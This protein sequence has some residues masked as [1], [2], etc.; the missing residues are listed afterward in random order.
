MKRMANKRKQ[1]T[2]SYGCFKA[3][4]RLLRLF[5]PRI[6]VEG[7]QKL[8]GE[9]AIIVGNHCQMHGPIICELYFPCRRYTWCA[10]E[11]MHLKEVPAYAF[12]DFWSRKPKYTHWFYKFLSYVVAP[13][14]VFIFRNAETI[15]VY[16]DSRGVSTFKSTLTKLE[17]GANI[18]LFPEYYKDHN[19]IINDFRDKFVDVA[20]LYYKRTGRAVSFVP[21]YIAPGLKKLVLG[22]PLVFDPDR[23][24]NQERQRVCDYIKKRI[25]AMALELP[26]HRVVPYANVSK[27]EYP[28]S[29]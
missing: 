25:T 24:V 19:H 18:V 1:G 27:K 7:A 14:S 3:A 6:T 17:E 15:P 28:M 11:M 10:G 23:P 26:R 4:K 5:Y 20:R 8:P 21:M 13:L 2:L 22:E 9:D 29:K 16:R 12:E